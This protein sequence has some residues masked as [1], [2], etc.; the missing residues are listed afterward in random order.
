[1]IKRSKEIRSLELISEN[2]TLNDIDVKKIYEDTSTLSIEDKI[3]SSLRLDR[4]FIGFLVSIVF[5][6]IASIFLAIL[7]AV[8]FV[9][10][11]PVFAVPSLII[12]FYMPFHFIKVSSKI[13]LN[14]GI[15]GEYYIISENRIIKISSNSDI[16][17]EIEFCDIRDIGL[18]GD[19]IIIQ[20]NENEIEFRLPDKN[21]FAKIHR[22]IYNI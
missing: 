10:Y 21:H 19:E 8:I 13:L 20:S 7:S 22:V 3:I 15:N 14:N 5:I 11:N 9:N 1:M 6:T 18:Q 2:N 4:N 16:K 17:K 12:S